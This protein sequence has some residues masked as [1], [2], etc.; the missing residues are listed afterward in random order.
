MRFYLTNSTEWEFV[1]VK[2]IHRNTTTNCIII[3]LQLFFSFTT[4]IEMF[5]ENNHQKF[6]PKLLQ[7]VSLCP[8][9]AFILLI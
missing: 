6:S 3:N 9:F 2:I 8:V 7:H 5:Q 4:E 1:P